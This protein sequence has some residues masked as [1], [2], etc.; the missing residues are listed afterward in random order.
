MQRSS[1]QGSG[2]VPTRLPVSVDPARWWLRR[3]KGIPG[4]SNQH[5]LVV[6]RLIK[7]EVMR[8]GLEAT[9]FPN[10]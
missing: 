5:L 2:Q 7:R 10:L 6:Y 1:S 8:R 9:N 4:M 3:P